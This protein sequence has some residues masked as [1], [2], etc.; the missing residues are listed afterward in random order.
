MAPIVSEPLIAEG[1][2]R[3]LDAVREGR[4][5]LPGPAEVLR[6]SRRSRTAELAALFHSVVRG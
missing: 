5:P 2:V 1:L 4:A 3:F 6:H